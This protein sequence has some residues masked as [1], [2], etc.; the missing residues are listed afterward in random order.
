MHFL[1]AQCGW[2]GPVIFA[3]PGEG[4]N[5]TDRKRAIDVSVRLMFDG[6][7]NS[8]VSTADHSNVLK[9]SNDT[10]WWDFV[11]VSTRGQSQ[12]QACSSIKV[13]VQKAATHTDSR[14]PY[15]SA[16]T[17][18]RIEIGAGE[19]VLNSGEQALAVALFAGMHG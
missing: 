16:F 14:W 9:R 2:L 4:V 12:F 15:R 11:C 19:R 3:T 6:R 1:N 8:A 18:A 13:A 5:P 17:A 7:H 10:C